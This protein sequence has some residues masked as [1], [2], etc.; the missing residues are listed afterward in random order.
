MRG[1]GRHGFASAFV[2]VGAL[3]AASLQLRAEQSVRQLAATADV[4]GRTCLRV[5]TT[6]L[7]MTILRDTDS[8][9]GASL[10]KA[11]ATIDYVASARTRNGGEVLLALERGPVHGP[12]G[13]SDLETQVSL[14]ASG[15]GANAVTDRPAVA[16]RWFG[17]GSRHG[18]ITFTLHASVPGSYS[19]PVRLTLAAP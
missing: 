10:Q 14:G 8:G 12:S 2:L 3:A 4:Q 5:S 9:A 13:A 19:V 7:V 17:S 15:L 6:T 11:V 16:V 18:T 1:I